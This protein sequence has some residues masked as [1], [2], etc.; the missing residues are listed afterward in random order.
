MKSRHVARSL[1]AHIL[2]KVVSALLHVLLWFA[3]VRVILFVR[4]V[5]CS[6]VRNVTISIRPRILVAM[7]DAAAT[8][9][10]VTV[11]AVVSL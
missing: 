3:D 10:T 1:E 11:I 7:F 9:I 2:R 6:A 4:E 5:G 8:V